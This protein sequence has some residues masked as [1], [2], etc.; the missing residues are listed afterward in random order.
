MCHKKKGETL[1]M[2][3]SIICDEEVIEKNVSNSVSVAE[4]Q[5]SGLTNVS[6]KTVETSR[7]Y[8][9]HIF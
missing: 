4:K 8:L 5:Q 7:D 2:T 1:T 9:V 3:E 6:M